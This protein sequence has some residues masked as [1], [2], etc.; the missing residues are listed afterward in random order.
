M[1]SFT[2]AQSAVTGVANSARN[3]STLGE[4]T[5]NTSACGCRVQAP[6]YWKA[7]GTAAE[8]LDA[9]QVSP[10]RRNIASIATSATIAV[11]ATAAPMRMPF[12]PDPDLLGSRRLVGTV[13]AAGEP[14]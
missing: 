9:T 11:I 13:G 12:P 6:G 7:T 2:V 10:P 1:I 4:T 14:R 8:P 3:C 5:T